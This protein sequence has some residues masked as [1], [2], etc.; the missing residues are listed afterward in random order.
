[1]RSDEGDE[2]SA[3]MSNDGNVEEL[4]LTPWIGERY[5]AGGRFGVRVL[6]LGKSSYGP[7]RTERPMA[8]KEVVR[9]F[10]QRARTGEGARHWYFT[11][12]ANVLRGQPGLIDDDDLAAIFQEVSFYNL[13]PSAVLPP[14]AGVLRRSH[15][16]LRHWLDAK[17]RLGTVLGEL[18]PDAVLVVGRELSKQITEWPDNVDHAVVPGGD[19]SRLWYDNAIP[20]F[21]A[22]IERAKR[23]IGRLEDVA[24]ATPSHGRSDAGGMSRGLEVR[25]EPP[26]SLLAHKG[27]SYTRLP[28]ATRF[29]AVQFAALGNLYMWASEVDPPGLKETLEVHL[30]AIG[31]EAGQ[32]GNL[33]LELPARRMPE[34]PRTLVQQHCAATAVIYLAAEHDAARATQV[35]AHLAALDELVTSAVELWRSDE[36]AASYLERP[37]PQLNGNAPIDLANRSLDGARQA[38]ATVKAMCSKLADLDAR[39]QEIARE[40]PTPTPDTV[41]RSAVDLFGDEVNARAF[42]E[43]P[44]PLLGGLKPFDV[45]KES[46]EGSAR[47]ARLLRQAQA[48]TA[49]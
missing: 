20:E 5:A 39:A 27:S 19:S 15:P 38:A 2:R 28:S 13:M 23:R 1:M 21:R 17:V 10:T 48:T 12:V 4:G 14:V 11:M 37:S 49:I 16:T 41:F 6:V 43:R 31:G 44:H 3:L 9:W 35:D 22:L 7:E 42:L 8:T 46:T 45:A 26:L 34:G 40:R 29:S 32:D 24:L 33:T 47:I 30:R 36:A 25:D 18:E